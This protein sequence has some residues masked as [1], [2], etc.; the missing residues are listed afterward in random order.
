MGRPTLSYLPS[1]W[2]RAVGA[3][4][5]VRFWLMGQARARQPFS[6]G[7]SEW[8]PV[9]GDGI[10]KEKTGGEAGGGEGGP[11]K[12]GRD[13]RSFRMGGGLQGMWDLPERG[14]TSLVL[15]AGPLRGCLVNALAMAQQD[16]FGFSVNQ[17]LPSTFAWGV[18][19]VT[20]WGSS[21]K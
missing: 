3:S 8:A 11:G 20:N 1:P 5:C 21:G 10:S 15:G 4:P 18:D 6:P 12:G 16:R 7:P 9:G 2:S 17:N 19:M 13:S 14:Q